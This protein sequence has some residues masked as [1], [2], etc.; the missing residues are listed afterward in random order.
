MRTISPG[1]LFYLDITVITMDTLAK[2]Q[3]S[4]IVV[5]NMYELIDMLSHLLYTRYYYANSSTIC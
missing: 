2:S 1:L 4:H 3:G 5:Y